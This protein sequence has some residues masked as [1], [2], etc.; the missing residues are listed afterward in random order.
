MKKTV[1]RMTSAITLFVLIS[2]SLMAQQDSKAP[3]LN[4]IQPVSRFGV[5][6]HMRRR[7]YNR[8]ALYA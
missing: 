5:C 4:A 1:I 2:Q 8:R 6:T 7:R 3:T